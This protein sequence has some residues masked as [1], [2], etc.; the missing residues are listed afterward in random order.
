[1]TKNE[2][3][4]IKDAGFDPKLFNFKLK[5][6]A[7]YNT[8]NILGEEHQD[9]FIQ[10]DNKGRIKA[11]LTPEQHQVIID[12]YDKKEEQKEI[13]IAVKKKMKEHIVKEISKTKIKKD[14]T[15][16]ELKLLK[17]D[18]E[19]LQSKLDKDYL[20]FDEASA[21]L[22]EVYDPEVDDISEIPEARV[23]QRKITNASSSGIQLTR[24]GYGI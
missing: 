9:V 11:F 2:K 10:T 14:M 20:A 4:L 24:R 13:D 19:A 21:K 17:E 16:K 6:N 15:K 3:K 7:T 23:L 1:M 12:E 5:P 22:K 18:P 8:G